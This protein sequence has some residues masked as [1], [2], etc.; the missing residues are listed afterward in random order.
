LLEI[1]DS[2]SWLKKSKRLKNGNFSK[3][4][5]EKKV[6]LKFQRELLTKNCELYIYIYIEKLH[7]RKYSNSELK[8]NYRNL[9]KHL[10]NISNRDRNIRE[11]RDMQ[12]YE[13]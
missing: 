4:T 7:S 12:E 5:F 13:N 3:A 11:N 8:E 1:F 10:E 2:D 9:W 6:D